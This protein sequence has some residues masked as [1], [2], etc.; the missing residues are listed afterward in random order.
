M[1]PFARIASVPVAS[2]A[3]VGLVF[4]DR[5]RAAG[6]CRTV[7]G[8]SRGGPTSR[9]TEHRGH[10]RAAR[11]QRS[12]DRASAPQGQRQRA[13][14]QPGPAVALDPQRVHA[15]VRT[16]AAASRACA[17]ARAPHPVPDAAAIAQPAPPRAAPG[18]APAPA[19]GPPPG[20]S[21]VGWV[22][23]P[24]QPERHHQAL[25][26][27]RDRPRNHVGQ[28]RSREQPGADGVR[29]HH[30]LLQRARQAVA[31]QH[32]VP[33]QRPRAVEDGQHPER[34][35][36]QQVFGLAAV[37][38]RAVQAGHQQHQVRAGRRRASFR[39]PASRSGQRST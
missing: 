6:R 35:C 1:S 21:L 3:A 12:A 39:R 31:V 7:H 22:T 30:R 8:R 5:R 14:A 37:G 26:D 27:H 28:R 29:R 36:E 10:S 25:R 18:P 34:R 23:G 13:A 16:G 11:R 9:G 32:D 33:H 15:A 20:T 17:A 24:R 4:G 2:A 38:A 19:P